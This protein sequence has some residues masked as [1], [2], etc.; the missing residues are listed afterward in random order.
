MTNKGTRNGNRRTDLRAL[1]EHASRHEV[2]DALD[3]VAG[4]GHDGAHGLS[5]PSV[6]LEA[7]AKNNREDEHDHDAV[8]LTDGGYTEVFEEPVEQGT[9]FRWNG[10]EHHAEVTGLYLDEDARTQIRFEEHDSNDET[11]ET[12]TVTVDDLVRVVTSGFLTEVRE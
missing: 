2:Y 6:A 3:A 12:R 9:V 1:D 4:Q 10:T 5:T 8:L 11:V 7:E